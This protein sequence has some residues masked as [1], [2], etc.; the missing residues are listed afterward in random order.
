MPTSM[1]PSR[2]DRARHILADA[3]DHAP[4]DR[5]AFLATACGEDA[6][7]LAEV[8]ALLAAHEAMPE[9]FLA[10]P[11]VNDI[12]ERDLDVTIKAAPG[13][14]PQR[15]GASLPDSTTVK[16]LPSGSQ[17]SA[18]SSTANPSAAVPFIFGKRIAQG[19][20]GAILETEDCKLG[21]TIAAKVM[22][23]EQDASEDM[24]QRFIQEA[25]VLAK[26]AHPNI[27]PVYDLGHDDEGQL[28]YTMK[29]VKGRTLQDILDDLR[30][31]AARGAAR[32]HP[33]APAHHLP[34]GVRRAGLRPQQGHH[35]PRPEAG[36]RDGR[37]VRRGAGDGL[38]AGENARMSRR[39]MTNDGAQ[40]ADQMISI[41]HSACRHSSFIRLPH[42][43]AA[44]RGDGHA[45]IHVAGAGDGAA[46]TNWMRA[47]TSSRSA[48]FFTP[49]SRCV[50]RWRARRWRRCWR[51]CPAPASRRP[52]P[53]GPRPAAGRS[54]RR[55]TVLE[56]KQIKPLPHIPAGRVPA[57]LS[58][59]AMKALTLD[60]ARRYQDVAAFSADIEAYQNGF[61]TT[62]EQAGLG[63]Q[64]VL[65]IK[66]HKGI[67]TTAAAAWLL[68]TA[69]AVWFVF[70]LRAKEQRAVG[71]ASRK[72]PP[73]KRRKRRTS[74]RGAGKGNGAAGAGEV[75]ARPRGKGIR[76]RQIR[77]GAE[78][79]RGDA[80]ELSRCELA[81][82]ARP[83]ARL[84]RAA[85]HPRK[86]RR[87]SVAVSAAGRSFRG[88]MLPRLHRHLYPHGPADRRLDSGGPRIFHG[89]FGIDRAGSRM[90]LAASANEVAVQEVATGKLVRRWT[91][92]I[93]AIKHVLLSPDGGTVLVAGGKQLI[94]YATQTGA[95]LWTQPYTGVIP[96]FSPDGRTV[97]ILA[98]QESG[99]DLKVQLLDTL[100]GAVRSTLEATADNPDKTTLQFNQ[101]GDRLACLGGDEVILWNPQTARENPRPPFPGGDGE[102]AESRRR[103]GGDLQRQPHPPVGHDDG[104][105]AAFAQWCRHRGQGLAF[106]PDGKMLLSSHRRASDGIVHVWPTRLGEEIASARPRGIPSLAASS[107]IATVPRFYAGASRWRG[108]LGDP[109][110]PPEMEVSPQSTG[111][112]LDLAIH[113]TDGSIILS[114]YGPDEHSPTCRPPGRRWRR[115][116]IRTIRA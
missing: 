111:R 74:R 4:E 60:K 2:P 63:K 54:R 24:R 69:L 87:E 73:P 19:G 84:H 61:A 22:L 9:S 85:F 20:M 93:G 76:A 6:A 86:G 113:P 5:E 52:R 29:L 11:A 100:T 46:S 106:S 55:A 94:A 98:V 37:R 116:D 95:P 35:P 50:R 68:I 33:G 44:G 56:A 21:R 49:S 45:E 102:A 51:K 64:L 71:W 25:A 105:I 41:R 7:L 81:L 107:S 78:D 31:R 90:A 88:Q 66:R 115:W 14:M 39:G 28:F 80:G 48:A 8:R 12:L 53:L 38:G 43:H 67:F 26:L 18:G 27:V 59:V 101:A 34:Q 57:A 110:R 1:T 17:T 70:N 77:R 23:L 83:L 62:A 97:A 104:A 91:C 13:T 32:V 42:P 103:R 16:T 89:T 99:L 3:L 58:A 92:E 82:P 79:P 47:R 10:E 40:S 65:L 96:A 75:A 109:E 108:R 114:E 36:E 30:L 112:I 72:P 15:T